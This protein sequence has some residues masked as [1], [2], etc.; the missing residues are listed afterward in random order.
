MNA[1]NKNH[2]G[3]YGLLSSCLVLLL[4]GIALAL[5]FGFKEKEP[6]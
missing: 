4:L 5:I 3:V 2:A 6:E 1:I